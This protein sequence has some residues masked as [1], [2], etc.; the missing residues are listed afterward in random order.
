MAISIVDMSL[1]PN[2]PS[3]FYLTRGVTIIGRGNRIN[4]DDVRL[5]PQTLQFEYDHD[6]VSVRGVR[7]SQILFFFL[8][9]FF[10][11][12]EELQEETF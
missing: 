9:L 3:I 2:T 5:P 6:T 7:G 8:F 1:L 11:L 12:G 4:T 10:Y